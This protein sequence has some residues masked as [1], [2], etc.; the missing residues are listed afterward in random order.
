[1]IG[2]MKDMKSSFPEVYKQ[3]IENEAFVE[4]YFESYRAIR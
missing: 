1:M 4:S 2:I 3:A